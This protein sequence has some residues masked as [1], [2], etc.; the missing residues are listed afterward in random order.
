MNKDSQKLP[1]EFQNDGK[2]NGRINQKDLVEDNDIQTDSS[3]II[4]KGDPNFSPDAGKPLIY[5]NN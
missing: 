2:I 3:V 5:K 4:G 1:Q